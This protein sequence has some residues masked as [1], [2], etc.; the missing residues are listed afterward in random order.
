MLL[1]A[2]PFFKS[3]VLPPEFVAASSARISGN[4]TVSVSKPAGTADGDFIIAFC[5]AN[6][7]NAAWTASPPD[8]S[9]TE[10]THNTDVGG[11]RCHLFIKQAGSSEPSSYS[12]VWSN[13]TTHRATL[14]TYR[15]GLGQADAF[16]SFSRNSSDTS[17]APGLTAI[18]N[19]T[20]LAFYSV[21]NT[22]T[23]SVST[24]PSGLT[25]RQVNVGTSGNSPCVVVYDLTPSPAGASGDHTLVWSRSDAVTAI[26][27][28]IK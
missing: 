2:P 7:T 17:L 22:G 14:L 11:R 10:I 9:W 19:G 21:D 12:F 28:Q 8:G 1:V 26:Q 24:P 6:T 25:E 27:L 16:G 4:T 20:L 3:S 13:S 15:G 23:V 5:I 18:S